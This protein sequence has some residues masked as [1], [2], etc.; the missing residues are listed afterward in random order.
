MAELTKMKWG[1]ERRLEF[2]EFRLLWE[3]GVNRSDIVDTFSVSEPQ[4]SKDLTLYQERAPHNAVYDRVARRY[5][6]SD[7]FQPVFLTRDPDEFLLRLRSL[8]EGLATA[9]DSWLGS[10][11][12]VDVVLTPER[13]VSEDCLRGVLAAHREKG[14]IEICYQSMSKNRTEAI[15][16]RVTPHAFGY[17]GFRWHVR[18]YCA[19]SKGFRDFLLPRILDVRAPG[20]P[21]KSGAEDMLWQHT[22]SIVIKPHPGLA[23]AQ[24]E[25]VAKDY[26]MTDYRKSLQVR[27]AMLFYVLKRL[28]LLDEAEKKDPRTQHIVLVNPD[29]TKE[30]LSKADW[31]VA[32]A[33]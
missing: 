2:I 29:Q 17:D 10:Q 33:Y 18:A 4:A 28:G 7:A 13:Q 12:D 24:R 5:V 27:Y 1:V 25:I 3:G 21:G 11:P 6:A 31:A 16:R 30:A 19:E 32:P 23:P 26:G 14:S 22:F 9:G 20:M 8:A 15:W